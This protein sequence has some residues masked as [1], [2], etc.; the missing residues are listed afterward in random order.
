MSSHEVARHAV[1]SVKA[2]HEKDKSLKKRLLNFLYELFIIVFAI[3]I[4]LLLE[5]SRERSNNDEIEK[6]FLIGFREDLESDIKELISDSVS[7]V[8]Q[9]DAALYFLNNT[10]YNPDSLNVHFGRF[11]SFTRFLPNNS[12]FEALRGSGKLYVIHDNELLNE[13]MNLYQE[14]V[15][16]ML[17]ESESYWNMKSLRLI[18]YIEDNFKAE[19]KASDVEK[20]LHTD[21]GIN[22][23][24][25]VSSTQF[26]VSK[27]HY[28]IEQVK[29]IVAMIDREFQ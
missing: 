29:K 10:K 20:L 9:G 2:L 18:P 26:L 21:K 13:I 16:S 17:L 14:K 11:Y 8:S 7:I 15:P 3:S 4:S 6:R 12:R 27:Y 28:T 25:Q 22:L 19:S 23:L 24:R 1:N 5:R